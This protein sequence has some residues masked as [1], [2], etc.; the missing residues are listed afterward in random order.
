MVSTGLLAASAGIS[1]S[2]F[3]CYCS[4]FEAHTNSVMDH[5]ALSSLPLGLYQI[6]L[7]QCFIST[8]Y[9]LKGFE[10]TWYLFCLFLGRVTLAVIEVFLSPRKKV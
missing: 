10:R 9:S 6:F 5:I 3:S 7:E 4:H 2:F 8:A 1:I